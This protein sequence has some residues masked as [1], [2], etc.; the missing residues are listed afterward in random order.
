MTKQSP[1]PGG[2]IFDVSAS[3]SASRSVSLGA[4]LGASLSAEAVASLLGPN[5][6]GQPS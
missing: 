5:F 3:L 6:L 1:K 2:A 4:S